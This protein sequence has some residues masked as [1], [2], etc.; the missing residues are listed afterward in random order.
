MV[1]GKISSKHNGGDGCTPVH[2]HKSTPS[3][4]SLS[5][6]NYFCAKVKS[7]KFFKNFLGQLGNISRI[8]Q[9]SLY[10]INRVLNSSRWIA[11]K[12]WH[13]ITHR[14]LR[15]YTPCNIP[16]GIIPTYPIS[17]VL[18]L[19]IGS[20]WWHRENQLWKCNDSEPGTLNF[21]NKSKHLKS[22]V[23]SLFLLFQS[24]DA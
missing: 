18:R 5:H 20:F 11:S 16:W 21:L 9:K 4:L 19:L 23:R 14:K 2:K 17:T 13:Q 22:V 3:S 7:S 12:L 24:L 6:Y 1:Q 8:L 10:Q 15:W